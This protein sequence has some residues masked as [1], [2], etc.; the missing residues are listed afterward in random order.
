MN[1]RVVLYLTP[2]TPYTRKLE[3]PIVVDLKP[4]EGFSLPL[5]PYTLPNTCTSA[6]KPPEV[7]LRKPSNSFKN[8][9]C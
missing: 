6:C 1:M 3:Q 4:G 5:G 9:L 7:D 2:K 8:E